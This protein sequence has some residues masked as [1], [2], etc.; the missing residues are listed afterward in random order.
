MA[1][2]RTTASPQSEAPPFSSSNIISK[3]LIGTPTE[4]I[5]GVPETY[6]SLDNRIEVPTPLSL[7]PQP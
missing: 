6:S 2:V 1:G 4:W 5:F 3:D 7:C